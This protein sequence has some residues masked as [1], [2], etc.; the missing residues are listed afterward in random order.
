M[1]NNTDKIADMCEELAQM[2]SVKFYNDSFPG[3]IIK[4]E[5]GFFLFQSVRLGWHKHFLMQR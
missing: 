1:L 4:D 5:Y 3:T 2:S